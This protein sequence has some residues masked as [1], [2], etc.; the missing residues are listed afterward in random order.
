MATEKGVLALTPRAGYKRPVRLTPTSR[1]TTR[2]RRLATWVTLFLGGCSGDDAKSVEPPPATAAA[3]AEPAPT[4]GA[5]ES[6]PP[7]VPGTSEPT[8]AQS[9]PVLCGGAYARECGEGRYCAF[10]SGCGTVG[11]C[12]RQRTGCEKIFEPVCGCDGQTYGNFC[13]AGSVGVS[14]QAEGECGPPELQVTCGPY[15]CEPGQYCIFDAGRDNPWVYACR[16]L[17]TECAGTPSCDCVG[18]AP[19]CP[20]GTVTCEPNGPSVTLTC[21]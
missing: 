10:D 20:N 12:L 3:G 4:T 8:P 19:W 21:N 5:M 2:C 15:R 9:D 16:S 11:D 17:P 6:P 14:V 7:P 1:S 13:E 18:D